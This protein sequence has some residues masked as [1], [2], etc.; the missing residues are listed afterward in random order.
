[1]LFADTSIRTRIGLGSQPAFD[2]DVA[3]RRLTDGDAYL[4]RMLYPRPSMHKGR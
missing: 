3:A 1:M 4:A 2:P